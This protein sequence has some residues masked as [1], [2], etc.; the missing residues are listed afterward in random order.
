V[1]AVIETI[2]IA[3]KVSCRSR[4]CFGTNRLRNGQNQKTERAM[5]LVSGKIATSAALVVLAS[6][7]AMLSTSAKAADYCYNSATGGSSCSY[8]TMEQCQ[9]MAAGRAAWCSRVIDWSAWNAEH[10]IAGPTDSY[11]YYSKGHKRKPAPVPSDMPV[12]GSGGF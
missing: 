4:S 1:T 9:A 11:A 2:T 6:S 7:A 10:G 3:T 5:K 12:K 8:T